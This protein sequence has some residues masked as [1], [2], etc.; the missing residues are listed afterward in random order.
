MEVIQETLCAMEEISIREAIDKCFTNIDPQNISNQM[1]RRMAGCL[2]LA[3][4]KK[5]GRYTSG[6][7]RSRVRYIRGPEAGP[8]SLEAPD[9]FNKNNF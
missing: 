8:S 4:W 5:E 3:G 2:Q 6:E 9:D 1:S 7:R